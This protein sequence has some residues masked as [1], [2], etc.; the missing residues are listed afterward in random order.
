M[1]SQS[2]TTIR[3]SGKMASTELAT[4]FSGLV[5]NL[6]YYLK[7]TYTYEPHPPHNSPEH[8]DKLLAAVATYVVTE[9]PGEPV[10]VSA[11]VIWVHPAN[12]A[13]FCVLPGRDGRWDLTFRI[14]GGASWSM[15]YNQTTKQVQ[16]RPG[17]PHTP[18]TKTGKW[19]L[20]PIAQGFKAPSRDLEVGDVFWDDSDGAWF[21]IVEIEPDID[22][23]RHYAVIYAPQRHQLNLHCRESGLRTHVAESDP[24]I[25]NAIRNKREGIAND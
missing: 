19:V 21:K 22:G 11:G 10:P 13:T 20:E 6:D 4:R 3:V 9:V 7:P 17:Y 25:Q 18:S 15:I 8:G 5:G 1:S 2:V 23:F 24:R 12:E 14:Q 16:D